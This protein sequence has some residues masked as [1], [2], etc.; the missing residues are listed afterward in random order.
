M[1][2][3]G[4]ARVGVSEGRARA[5]GGWRVASGER[6]GSIAQAAALSTHY[7][8]SSLGPTATRLSP[9]A[10]CSCAAASPPPRP[11]A[12][13][14]T[15]PTCLN[16]VPSHAPPAPAPSPTAPP[17]CPALLQVS[18]C[19][20]VSDLA[21]THGWNT[22]LAAAAAEALTAGGLS[23]FCDNGGGRAGQGRAGQGRAGQGR[24]GQGRAGQDRRGRVDGVCVCDPGACRP[25][26][27][28]RAGGGAG[29]RQQC[30]SSCLFFPVTLTLVT[31]LCSA[32]TLLATRTPLP[33]SPPPPAA[34][35]AVPQAVASGLLAPA[36]LRAA[37][38][39]ML[40][41]R[42]R[43]GILGAAQPNTTNT[44]DS[45]SS[46]QLDTS[47]APAGAS[48]TS[49]DGTLS[50]A[51]AAVDRSGNSGSGGGSGS[52]S[53]GGSGSSS[54]SGSG[55]G[56]GRPDVQALSRSHAH[57]RLAYEAALRSITLLVNRPPPGGSGGRPLLPLQ[58]PPPPPAPAN[59]TDNTTAAPGPLLA[60]LGPHADGALYY[61][62]TY[63]GTPS[64]EGGGNRGGEKG[65]RQIRRMWKGGAGR[66]VDGLRVTASVGRHCSAWRR[67]ALG[68]GATCH[69]THPQTTCPKHTPNTHTTHI[70][71]TRVCAC[72]PCR[73][74]GDAA[75]RAA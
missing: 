46:T 25:G 17:L 64:R 2:D 58:L 73:P 40:L 30:C 48:S 34:A 60:L 69:P 74:G 67:M 15:S 29:R 22:S 37:V 66:A 70:R 54:G 11:P 16:P 4:A 63:Y 62:G 45:S 5:R 68:T 53:G 71:P 27:G 52:G 19:G 23:L 32:H 33:R 7:V 55:S 13:Y 42:C 38:R 6:P 75:G 36:V 43:L 28:A 56:S 14:G 20:A 26:A 49:A 72:R 18:D 8:V 51:E 59:T 57:T 3:N 12:P 41:A 24:A 50:Q 47:E 21:L 35:A 9:A 39:R 10:P 31:V 61:L 65:R 44:T 1:L